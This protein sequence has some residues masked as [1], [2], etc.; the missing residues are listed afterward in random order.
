M[1]EIRRRVFEENGE[2]YTDTSAPRCPGETECG[3]FQ[4]AKSETGNG[5]DACVGCEMLPTKNGR[6][7]VSGRCPG[8]ENCRDFLK[9]GGATR[10]E[11]EMNA[12][13]GCQF[14]PTKPGAGKKKSDE[15][16]EADEVENLVN[17]IADIVFWEDAGSLTDWNCYPFE[18]HL[19]Y[20]V[21]REAEKQIK[22]TREIVMQM[23]IKS[24][25]GTK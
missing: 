19:L 6:T 13:S 3:A 2:T 20:A 15:P 21:W 14:F 10:E 5:L 12:C 9:E 24:F 16:N 1:R 25:W 18:T 23:F 22:N 8:E 17:E 7:P 4:I 11:K